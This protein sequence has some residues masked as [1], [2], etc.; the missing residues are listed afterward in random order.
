[1]SCGTKPACVGKRLLL[2][3]RNNEVTERRE[4]RRRWGQTIL[5]WILKEMRGGNPRRDLPLFLFSQSRVA[6]QIGKYAK[7]RYIKFFSPHGLLAVNRMS[8]WDWS[9]PSRRY[10]WVEPT[11][12][13]QLPVLFNN[14]NPAI[15]TSLVPRPCTLDHVRPVP[16]HH[17]GLAFGAPQ[18]KL[19]TSSWRE[20]C[21]CGAELQPWN[22]CDLALESYR[23]ARFRRVSALQSVLN[24]GR[25]Y[26]MASLH[27]WINRPAV[28][29]ELL[30]LVSFECCTRETCWRVLGSALNLQLDLTTYSYVVEYSD[31]RSTQPFVQKLCLAAQTAFPIPELYQLPPGGIEGNDGWVERHQDIGHWIDALVIYGGVGTNLSPDYVFVHS[32]RWTYTP[33]RWACAVQHRNTRQTLIVSTLVEYLQKAL[34]PTILL[35]YLPAEFRVD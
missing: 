30:R 6:E 26:A 11:P 21:Q 31:Q 34:V 23:Y 15:H 22:G 25:W 24:E 18:L 16:V 5:S 9:R 10:L 20:R 19:G 8:G 28:Q 13:S 33:T 4:K 7:F 12:M 27:N 17:F 14:A 35:H 29:E 2:V 1:M 3:R 32:C